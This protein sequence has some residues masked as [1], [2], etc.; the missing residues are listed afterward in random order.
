MANTSFYSLEDYLYNLGRAVG[1][2][3]RFLFPPP[4]TGDHLTC[5]IGGSH[6]FLAEV[7]GWRIAA[8][9]GACSGDG[10]V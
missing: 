8:R 6:L 7:P 3:F 2:L 4:P 10:G 1:I 9:T 5:P